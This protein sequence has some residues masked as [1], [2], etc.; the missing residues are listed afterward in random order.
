MTSRREFLVVSGAVAAGAVLLGKE[1]SAAQAV[2]VNRENTASKY[3]YCFTVNTLTEFFAFL[4]AADMHVP[5]T[6]MS[7]E[8]VPEDS[9]GYRVE[10]R[11]THLHPRDCA[12]IRR[13][14]HI[15][16]KNEY[17]T[18]LPKL[19]GRATSWKDRLLIKWRERGS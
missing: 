7:I 14:A 3:Q 19:T 11:D 9:G 10:I 1:A 5:S 13:E 16:V 2:T 12:R 15:L 18:I 4:L 17:Y 6:E 8:F